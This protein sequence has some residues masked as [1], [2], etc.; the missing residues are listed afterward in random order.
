VPKEE[1][2]E[3]DERAINNG[4]TI[5]SKYSFKANPSKQ[6]KIKSTSTPRTP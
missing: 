4:A 6:H 5:Y 2:I 1:F 3:S